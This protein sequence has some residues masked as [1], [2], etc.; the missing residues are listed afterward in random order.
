MASHKLDFLGGQH[1]TEEALVLPTQLS[2]VR[3]SAPLS[4]WTANKKTMR[5]NQKK[6][7]DLRETPSLDPHK[8]VEPT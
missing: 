1:S 5:S 8:V 4:E 7:L 3:F 2:Q 6:K